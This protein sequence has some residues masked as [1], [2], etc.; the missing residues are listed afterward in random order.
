M[1]FWEEALALTV[2]EEL[3]R[4]KVSIWLFAC[5]VGVADIDIGMEM[6]AGDQIT[7]STH[8]RGAR[9]AALL[10]C[11]QSPHYRAAPHTQR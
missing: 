9:T 6:H 5:G 10:C 7:S 8:A 3:Q 2:S 4:Q 1:T 11:I